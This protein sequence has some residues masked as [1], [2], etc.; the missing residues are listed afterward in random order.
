MVVDGFKILRF[1]GV[2][3]HALIALQRHGDIAHQVFDEFGMVVGALGDVL[4][5]GPLEQAPE[6]ARGRRL[7]D[8]NLLV[9]PHFTAQRGADGDMRALV[10]RAVIGDFLGAGAQAGDRHLHL[11]R[12][13]QR[14]RLLRRVQ[15]DFVIHQ[16][17]HA[18]H[19]RGLAGK[20]GEL[21]GDGAFAGL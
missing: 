11:L 19:R 8:A 2:G 10:V 17:L 20:V 16:A 14:A 1:H 4:F 12:E 7:G 3:G 9:Q 15:G 6:F 18:R 21:R 13:R 5:V